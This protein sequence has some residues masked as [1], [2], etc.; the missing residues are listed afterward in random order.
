MT[1]VQQ[2]GRQDGGPFFLARVV[3]WRASGLGQGRYHVHHVF[4][5]EAGGG[6][7]D[8]RRVVRLCPC[9]LHGGNN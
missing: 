9:K 6:L 2:V 8:R 4:A 7:R 5:S 3:G 1:T